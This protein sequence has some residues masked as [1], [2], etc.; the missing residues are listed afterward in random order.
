MASKW[1]KGFV[2]ESIWRPAA[3][4]VE[5][6]YVLILT[7]HGDEQLEKFR[8]GFSGPTRVSSNAT[9]DGGKVVQQLSNFCEIAPP[10]GFVLEP[11]ASWT[12][13]IGKLYYPVRHWTDGATTGFV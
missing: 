11:G 6:Q 1:E 7:N 4:G 2:L 5:P 13:T 9:I 12:I 8:L 10:S 3:L